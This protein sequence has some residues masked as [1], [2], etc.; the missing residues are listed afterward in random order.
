MCEGN[1]IYAWRSSW[2]EATLYLRNENV[3]SLFFFFFFQLQL[4]QAAII[5]F[6]YLTLEVIC[7]IE[8]DPISDIVAF[9]QSNCTALLVLDL[10]NNSMTVYNPKI[11][12]RILRKCH[13]AVENWVCSKSI[14]SGIILFVS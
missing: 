13:I 8:T 14:C 12:V 9:S 2:A 1:I 10:V 6:A 4:L 11:C 3:N 7:H 5:L